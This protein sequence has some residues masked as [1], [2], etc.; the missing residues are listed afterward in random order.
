M[1]DGGAAMA[2]TDPNSLEGQAA[3]GTGGAA[4]DARRWLALAIV[5][6][7]YFMT[8]LDVSIVTVAL[9]SISRSL[10][11]SASG[12]QWVIT[13]YAITFGG[14]LLLGGRFADLLGRRLVF[15]TGVAV[16]TAA[17]LVCGLAGSS[18]VLIAAR[19]VQGVGAALV[20]PATLSIITTTFDEGAD[21]NRALGIWGAMGGAGA[22]AGVLFGG[23]LTRYL[24]W[25]WIFFVNIPVGAA[26]L[27]VTRP[28]VR[29]SRDEPER[30]SFDLLGATAVTGGLALLV[31]GVS[32]AP[33]H[34]W[35]ATSTIASL[36][37]AGALLVFF[38]VWEARVRAPLMPLGIFRIR[39]V[40]GANAASVFLGALTFASFF[41]LT[42]YVQNVLHY[43]ALKTGL[44][45]FATAGTLVAVAAIAQALSTRYGPR[46]VLAAGFVTLTAGTIIY[47]QIPVHGKFLS[48]LLPGYLLV[49]VGLALAFIAVSIAGLAGVPPRLAGVASGLLITSQQI[50]GAV[51]TAMVSSI[52]LSRADHLLSA[53]RSPA[54]AF[55]SGYAIAFWVLAGI[56]A[57]GLVVSLALV[58]PEAAALP[59]EEPATD[60]A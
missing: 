34:G 11:F 17:S 9:P 46:P 5:C 49:G 2:T 35:G 3:L 18:A 32:E 55:T 24:G 53:G 33:A 39:T 56:G 41:L 16:F 44:T 7:A 40:A 22:A 23:I 58:R 13:A 30:R 12:L 26:V 57:A 45:F 42:L 8:V 50:G 54:S 47:A 60:L 43:S 38:V 14:F 1:T 31:Y 20:S 4:P 36:A 28:F 15:M 19:T 37:A 6:V 51:G 48:N 21:R 29:E 10:H 27:A 59:K 52:S 25:E